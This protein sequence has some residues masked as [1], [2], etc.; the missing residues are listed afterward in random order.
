MF[1][2]S[3]EC[4]KCGANLLDDPLTFGIENRFGPGMGL[5]K[6]SD[7]MLCPK[8][9]Y[10]NFPEYVEDDINE[11]RASTVPDEMTFDEHWGTES[12][13]GDGDNIMQESE[14]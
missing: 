2:H 14:D 5:E 6:E 4:E 13:E 12:E 7:A 3:E 8:C 10:P 11:E 1:I 9:G